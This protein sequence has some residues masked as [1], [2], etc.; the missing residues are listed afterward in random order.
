MGLGLQHLYTLQEALRL[1]DIVHH[2]YLDTFTGRL[3][4][5]SLELLLV[6]LRLGT[7]LA[8]ISYLIL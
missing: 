6:E 8:S 7:D 2:T 4:C 3:Y 5:T 1:A